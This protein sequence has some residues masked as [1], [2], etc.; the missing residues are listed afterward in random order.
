MELIRKHPLRSFP[1]QIKGKKGPDVYA[2]DNMTV[3]IPTGN[4]WG[5]LGPQR[6]KTTTLYRCWFT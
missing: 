1:R 4:F 3:E 6:E 5:L 2:V